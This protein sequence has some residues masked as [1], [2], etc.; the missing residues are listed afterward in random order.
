MPLLY[1]FSYNHNQ[2]CTLQGLSVLQKAV[3]TAG[4]SGMSSHPGLFGF[5]QG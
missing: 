5:A 2:Q 4:E 3:L 1:L